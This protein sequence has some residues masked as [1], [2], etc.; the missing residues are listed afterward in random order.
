MIKGSEPILNKSSM[1]RSSLRLTRMGSRTIASGQGFFVM[2]ANGSSPQLIFN[3]SA[4]V[5]TQNTGLNLFMAAKGNV[6]SQNNADIHPHLRL[7]MAM[8]SVN[9][10]DMYIGFNSAASTRYADNEDAPYKAGNGIVKLASYTNDNVKVAINRMPLPGQQQTTIRL[11]VTANAYGAY[12]LRMTAAA[13]IPQIYDIW[14]MDRFNHDSLDIRHNTNYVFNIT[15]DTGSYGGNRFKL[16][17][18]QNPA[19][20]LHLLNFTAAKAT[21]GAQ[22]AWT[23]ENEQN[24]TNFTVER[25]TDNGAIFDVLGGFVSSA[26]GT[27]SFQD[28]NPVAGANQ[29]RL[30]LEDLNGTVTYSAIVTV[31]YNNSVNSLVKNSVAI[32]PN[33]AKSTLNLTITPPFASGAYQIGGPAANPSSANTVYTIRIVNTLGAVVQSANTTQLNW[34]TDVSNLLPGTYIMQV[35]NSYNSSLVGKG[36]F[37]K[38]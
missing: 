25:S 35:V 29:Y 27:Y 9:T 21:G 38:L 5:T 33:P 37:V 23:T 2:A 22:A 15:A 18:R 6:I 8:D 20:G 34:Q 31:M 17:I 11:F 12:K 19:L 32:Y 28:Y 1:P 7:Q 13:A 4:K 30:K 36:T 10:D 24:Y 14:L 26:A 16:V 3:E